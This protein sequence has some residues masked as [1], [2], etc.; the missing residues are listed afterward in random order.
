MRNL[1]GFA[2]FNVGLSYRGLYGFALLGVFLGFHF[3]GNSFKNTEV[4]PGF[5]MGVCQWFL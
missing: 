5:I 3:N 1:V 4:K 2:A